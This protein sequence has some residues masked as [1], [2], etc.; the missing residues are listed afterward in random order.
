MNTIEHTFEITYLSVS[1][2]AEISEKE[3][4]YYPLS[5]LMNTRGHPSFPSAFLS[6]QS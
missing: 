3:T 6:G 1:Q 4:S 2:A 5:Q